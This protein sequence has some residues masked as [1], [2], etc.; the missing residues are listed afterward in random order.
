MASRRN[1]L[2]SNIA[3][4][5]NNE[6]T[7]IEN[8]TRY[9][10]N[11]VTA[12]CM[13]DEKQPHSNEDIT[14]GDTNCSHPSTATQLSDKPEHST[15][16]NQDDDTEAQLPQL[17]RTGT[18]FFSPHMKSQRKKILYQ[19]SKIILI[20]MVFIFIVFPLFWGASY[21]TASHYHK[22]NLIAV[23]QEDIITPDMENITL[24]LTSVLPGI[25][26][27]ATCNWHVYNST[28]FAHKYNIGNDVD[29]IEKEMIH[30]IH[31]EKFWFALNIKPNS[32]AN[33]YNALTNTSTDF[34]NTTAQYDLIY[35][36][37]RDPNTV[38]SSIYPLVMTVQ[39]AFK[40]FYTT[41]Y[42]PSMVRN[43][44]NTDI[45]VQNAVRSGS[46]D[47]NEIDYRP[48]TDRLL[49][50]VTQICCVY[51]IILAVFQFMN[52]ASLHGE[53]S[54]M[55]NDRSKITYRVLFSLTTFF[56]LS[57]FVC[58]V[59]VMYSV[60]FTRA[61]GHAGFMV[62]W[63]STWLFMWA[64]GS[65]TENI[66]GLIFAINPLFLGFWILGFVAT[67]IATSFF[68]FA[69]NN[70]FYRFGYA[71]PVHNLIDIYRVIFFDLSP[72]K[73]GRNYG[74]LVAWVAINIIM[75]PLFMKLTSKLMM[76]KMKKEAELAAAKPQN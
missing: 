41:N 39:A 46:M 70:N 52:F 21:D 2:I 73:M 43:I 25:L 64:V 5:F 55:L 6:D 67:N 11:M 42:L 26:D 56:F 63:M 57:L 19:F 61:F 58:T 22:V 34:F 14:S 23:I 37:G 36:S 49:M 59:T 3:N 44:T 1:S 24:P 27:Q 68:P 12:P 53:V 66:I 47:W 31:S 69:L 4:D 65:A 35:E 71:M 40:S 20:L 7:N 54:S 8:G 10:E 48:F 29:S 9:L 74:I 60:D 51:I 62:Y 16:S 32:T 15:G 76:R 17:T 45:N 28:G 30:L 13:P 72:H 38:K 33:L 18:A 50:V 75:L